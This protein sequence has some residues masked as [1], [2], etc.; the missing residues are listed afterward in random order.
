MSKAVLL[1]PSITVVSIQEEVDILDAIHLEQ[2]LTSILEKGSHLVLD[3]GSVIYLDSAGV[4]TVV[5]LF[6]RGEELGLC[7][8]LCRVSKQ[9]R[10][11]FWASPIECYDP[12]P[13]ESCRFIRS[14]CPIPS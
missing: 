5:N 6:K 7:V 4:K 12:S 1:E 8:R 14:A 13:E 9:L 3:L 2:R 11:L 10:D